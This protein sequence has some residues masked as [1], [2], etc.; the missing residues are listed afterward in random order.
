MNYGP[1]CIP[2]KHVKLPWELIQ[3]IDAVTTAG[4]NRRSMV[5]VLLREAL[6]ARKAKGAA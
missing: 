6:D 2:D 5:C 4:L 1:D 3:E